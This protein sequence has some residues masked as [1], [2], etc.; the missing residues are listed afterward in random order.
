MK[1]SAR[2]LLALT[3]LCLALFAYTVKIRRPWFGVIS[4]SLSH[5]QWLTCATMLITRNW[6]RETPWKLAFGL[7]N[8]PASVEFPSLVS[9]GVYHS[10]PPGAFFPVYILA[11]VMGHE[12]GPR[13]IMGW[14]LALHFLTA[15]GLSWLVFAAL[16]LADFAEGPAFGFACLPLLLDLFSPG[17]LYWHQNVYMSDMAG[18][19]P[20]IWCV[21]LELLLARPGSAEKG[22]RLR[23][24]QGLLLFWGFFTEWL[25]F[26]VGITLYAKRLLLGE[27]GRGRREMLKKSLG[28]W[29]GPALAML[30]FVL[31]QAWLDPASFR[32]LFHDFLFRS[33]LNAGPFAANLAD[34]PANWWPYLRADF[35]N[36]EPALL[37]AAVGCW[38]CLGILAAFRVRAGKA[39]SP[40]WKILFWLVPVLLVPCVLHVLV[41]RSYSQIH[42]YTSVKFE[43]SVCTV[44]F[45]L[46]PALALVSAEEWLR[47]RVPAW[48]PAV[49]AGLAVLFQLSLTF[50]TF[51]SRFPKFT[52]PYGHVEGIFR[53]DIHFSD[54]VFS[55]S[56]SI[57]DSPPHLL[58]FTMKRVYFIRSMADIRKKV[59]GIHRPFNVVVMF[60]QKPGPAWKKRLAR[61]RLTRDLD[62]YIYRLKP[63]QW[64]R[65]S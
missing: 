5:H 17:P 43:T 15:L 16:R 49:A 56:F 44:P 50:P 6:Y 64:R 40:G 42:G 27:M 32:S 53:R 19:M 9:R 29:C 22:R 55:P 47:V 61:A 65:G 11:E 60:F 58:A 24:A 35:G 51:P 34:F 38:A 45:A 57:P 8:N 3:L 37:L 46:V 14:N 26:F 2:S 30:L 7:F 18:T 48:P 62:C 20:Y 13:M 28:F 31:Q 12:P 36:S 63:D 10:Y 39:L 41:F 23:L 4:P 21:F 59:E 1:A 25:F 54:V 52:L 33:G